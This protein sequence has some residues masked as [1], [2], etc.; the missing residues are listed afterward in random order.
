RYFTVT[1]SFNLTSTQYFQTIREK[2]WNKQDSAVI[3]DTVQGF[4]MFNTY[5]ANVTLSTNVYSM[6]SLG[7]HRAITIRDVLYPIIGFTYQPDFSSSAYN[8]FQN[9]VYDQY[10]HTQRYSIFQDGIYGGP[11][12]GKQEAINF[13]LANNIEMKVRQHTDSGV[14]YKKVKLLERLSLSTSYNTVADSFRWGGISVG[15][16]TTLFKKLAVNYNGTIDPYKMNAY[17]EN[18]NQLVWDNGQ[19]GRFVNNTLTLSTTLTPGSSKQQTQ[20]QGQQNQTGQTNNNNNNSKGVQFTSPDQYFDYIQNR[21]AYYAPLELSQWSI[22]MNYSISNAVNVGTNSANNSLQGI[23]VNMSAQVTKYW[24]ASIYTGYDFV[25]HQFTSTSI[26]AKRDMHC[27]ELIFNTIP[28]GFHQD[29]SV[30]V[31]VKSSV[32]QDLKLT[33]QRSWEDT[34]QYQ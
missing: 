17:G 7:I 30:E 19:V 3:T 10:G 27:W 5:N 26:S 16:T 25:G 33:R 2:N 14:V 23:T 1:P 4:Q 31:H 22:T 21:P 32:L 34:Q 20:T 6:Y 29:F 13:S 15:A 12:A 9:V 24:Y 28:F 11:S 8:Y 18:I